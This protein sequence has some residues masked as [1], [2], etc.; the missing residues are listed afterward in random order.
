MKFTRALKSPRYVMFEL[1]NYRGG[2][3]HET[4]G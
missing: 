2:M 4:K 1:R 3:C